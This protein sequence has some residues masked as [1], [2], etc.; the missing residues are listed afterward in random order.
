MPIA[1]LAGPAAALI[2]GVFSARGQSDANRANERIARENRAFQER[3]SNTAVQRRAKDMEAAGINRILAGKFDAS[4]PAGAMA[5]MQNVGA[6][7]TE[8]A[9][10]GAS[11]AAQVASMGLIKAQIGATQAQTAKTVAEAINIRETKPGIT[12]RNLM[13]SHGEEVASVA[14]DVVRVIRSLI[15][16]KTPEEIAKLIQT[17]IKRA[18]GALTN[19]ME[20]SANS[21]KN[22]KQMINDLKQTIQEQ[23]LDAGPNQLKIYDLGR[24]YDP[25]RDKTGFLN[26]N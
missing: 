8:G 20:S 9:A 15:G 10:K 14:A 19:A 13:L 26:R 21:A 4:S 12:T 3:M 22:I 23:V 16:N 1:A 7:G 6:A 17:Q 2:G 11:T 5:T 18:Q 24:A 25:E